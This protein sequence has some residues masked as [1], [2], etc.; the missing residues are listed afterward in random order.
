MTSYQ[1]GGSSTCVVEQ[2]I[3]LQDVSSYLQRPQDAKITPSLKVAR[4]ASQDDDPVENLPSPT[5]Q[6]AEKLER[7][8]QSRTNIS[9]TFAAFWSFIVMGSNDAAY[10]ALIPY[11]RSHLLSHPSVTDTTQQ[12]QEYYNLTFIVISLVFLS[13][14]VGYTASALLNNTI[15]LKFGQRGIGVVAPI[16]HLLAYIVIAVHPPYPVLVVIF[17]IAGFGNGLADAAW[18]AWMGN[19]ANPNEVLGFLHASYGLGAV[20]SPLIATTMITK[21][22]LQ[23]YTF[24]YVMIA[25]AALELA[26][27]ASA[28]W[29]ADGAAFRAANPRT[30][31][32]RII[33]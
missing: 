33:G 9:R 8:N 28:F 31:M 26:V 15:H 32:R 14:L 6:A 3:E 27:S 22:H 24:Y 18:N 21:G 13:P 5:T 23:W 17:T 30:G 1:N 12:L 10:G 2:Q 29:K 7:W 25:M 11:V 20:L 16:C 4:R 19:M